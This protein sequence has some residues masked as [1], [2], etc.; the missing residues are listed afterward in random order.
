MPKRY[1]LVLFTS[2][3]FFQKKIPQ[4]LSDFEVE[5]VT[6]ENFDENSIRDFAPDFFLVIYFG[7]ILPKEVLEIPKIA[8]INIHFSLLPKYRGPAPV[9]WAVF[10]GEK[11]TGISC[12]FLT[13]EVD[14]GDIIHQVKVEIGEE[15]SSLQVFEKLVQLLPSCIS[16]TFEKILSEDF[17]PQ[18][19]KGTPTWARFL[20]KED[21]FVDFYKDNAELIFR[22]VLG[23]T[24]K[25]KVYALFKG[26]RL[27]LKEVDLHDDLPLKTG[28]IALFKNEKKIAVKCRQGSLL[29]NKVHP[30]GKRVMS[31]WDF[32]IGR[33]LKQGDFI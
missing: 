7:K 11:E 6:K 21:G 29:L 17:K 26:K 33:R 3:P 32:A 20:K 14:A 8:G 25:I 9:E 22:K 23:F 19:Q 10:N 24:S 27:I 28:E 16:K 1:K 18:K 15:E 13:E 2:Y 4:I 12:V 31:G 30:E 5:L